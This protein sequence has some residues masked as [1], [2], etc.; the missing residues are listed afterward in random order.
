MKN[1]G[2]LLILLLLLAS[3]KPKNN[4]TEVS[5][6]KSKAGNIEISK[7]AIDDIIQNISSP[8]EM[9]AL[10]N[11]LGV[12]FDKDN[13]VDLDQIDDYS[14]NFEMAYALGMLGA[15]LGYLNVYNKTG[16]SVRYLRA[17]NR[18]ADGLGISEFFDFNTIKYLATNSS[19]LD[20]LIFLSVRSFNEM[21]NQLRQTGRTDLS[22]LMIAGVWIEGMYQLTQVTKKQFSADLA[23]Y[24]GEQKTILNNLLI[25][26][27]NFGDDPN[28][29]SLIKDYMKL[30]KSFDSVKISYEIGEPE[31][32]ERDGMLI[33]VQQEKSKVELDAD[34]L[35]DIIEITARIRNKH[36]ES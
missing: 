33:V 30:K 10:V 13:L 29:A 22:A 6:N 5:D 36:L 2:I 14:Q 20:S 15:D 27:E 12:P 25:I 17:I 16:S 8:I 35:N 11:D 19:N 23:E 3:C 32:M 1:L 18:F 28:F 7:E 26:L 24:I 21:D 4:Q 34:V 31:T 9:A